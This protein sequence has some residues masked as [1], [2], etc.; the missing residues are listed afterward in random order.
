MSDV[1]ASLQIFF[2]ECRAFLP[3]AMALPGAF[4]TEL[5]WSAALSAPKQLADEVLCAL[6]MAIPLARVVRSLDQLLVARVGRTASLQPMPQPSPAPTPLAARV[7]SYSE[8]TGAMGA[9]V[10]ASWKGQLERHVPALPAQP[11]VQP[12]SQTSPQSQEEAAGQ[13]EEA[14]TEE[15]KGSETTNAMPPVVRRGGRPPE[16]AHVQ[17]GAAAEEKQVATKQEVRASQEVT[18]AK[19]EEVCQQDLGSGASSGKQPPVVRRGGRPPKGGHV[20]QEE[21][22]EQKKET[23]NSL[24]DAPRGVVDYTPAGSALNDAKERTAKA[25]TE[26]TTRYSTKELAAIA[27]AKVTTHTSGARA[28]TAAKP[29]D[30]SK[31]D[32]VDSDDD[33]EESEA[34]AAPAAAKPTSHSKSDHIDSEENGESET[35]AK[36][37]R[38]TGGTSGHVEKTHKSAPAASLRGN[39][40]DDSPDEDDP[41]GM[42]DDVSNWPIRRLKVRHVLPV[43]K[44]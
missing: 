36:R 7:T 12:P 19:Q 8:P 6:P 2:E 28:P 21:A 25:G 16:D 13:K 42:Q 27:G 4:C 44:W 14:A 37:Q 10:A 18:S 40:G 38:G 34:P 41:S 32:H 39:D 26:S 15:V 5:F 23:I 33:Q 31:W 17:Q 29:I 43:S 22:A 11:R 9:A 20:Q 1:P 35:P 30:Y 3:D 24:R